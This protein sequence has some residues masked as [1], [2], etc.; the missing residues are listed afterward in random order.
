MFA[1]T[2]FATVTV[3]CSKFDLSLDLVV[4]MLF[5]AAKCKIC[6]WS[7]ESEPVFLQHMKNTHKPGEMPYVCQVSWGKNHLDEPY[8]QFLS[9]DTFPLL[10]QTIFIPRQSSLCSTDMVF[11]STVI[12]EL[13]TGFLNLTL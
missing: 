12:T 3:N 4:V 11:L 8:Y 6:E 10:R 1:L 5:C 9:I 7:F 2:W 13:V